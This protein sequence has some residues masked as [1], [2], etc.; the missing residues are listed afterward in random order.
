ML[1][2]SEVVSRTILLAEASGAL[3]I[4]DAATGK[5]IY[6][7]LLVANPADV[8]ALVGLAR[9]LQLDENNA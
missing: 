4:A 6:E 1:S 8:E 9:A 3:D 7:Q 2:A 5:R